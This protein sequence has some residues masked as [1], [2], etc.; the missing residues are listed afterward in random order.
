MAGREAFFELQVCSL[1]WQSAAPEASNAAMIRSVPHLAARFA[2]ALLVFLGSSGE[3]RAQ[4][5]RTQTTVPGSPSPEARQAFQAR[6][7]AQARLLA[8]DRRLADLAQDKRQALVEF[9]VGNVLFAATHEIGLALLA[10]MNLPTLSS[11]EHAADDFSALTVLKLGEKDFSDRVLIEAGKGWFVSVRRANKARGTYYDRHGV[12]VRRA[13][14][15]A[16]LMVGADPVRFSALAEETALP[17]DMRRRCG[18][19]YDRALSSWDRTLMPYRPAPDQPK[20]RIEVSY[21]AATG[22]L[23]VYAQMFRELRFLETIA[24]YA[25]DR[26]AW[27]APV[28]ME[29]RS[30]RDAGATWSAA[31]RTLQI[32]YEMARDLAELYRDLHAGGNAHG[33]APS[34]RLERRSLWTPCGGRRRIQPAVG[35]LGWQGFDSAR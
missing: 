16:C 18:F 4:P 22:T 27:R 12:N 26:F 10:E 11:A 35:G 28:A 9:I 31:T 25:A 6:I 13:Y 17:R 1:M 20:A 24:E 8:G 33:A 5:F 32:C 15:I 14:R 2:A 3:L 19:D 30:C 21:G 34:A 7:D 23:D 29:M